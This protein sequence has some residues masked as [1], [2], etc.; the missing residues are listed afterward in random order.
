MILNRPAIAK[1]HLLRLSG[2]ALVLTL[3]LLLSPPAALAVGTGN[4]DSL[5]ANII[6]LGEDVRV[7]PTDSVENVVAFGGNI[8]VEGKVRSNVIAFGGDIEVRD[9]AVVGDGMTAEDF[10]VM[11]FG[12]TVSEAPGANVVGKTVDLGSLDWVEG[13]GE[14]LGAPFRG[15]S[16]TGWA[17]GLAFW[18]LVAFLAARLAPRQVEA[19]SKQLNRRPLPSLGWGALEALIIFP[20][21]TLLLVIT[22]VGIFAAVPLALFIMPILFLGG[23]LAAA[24]IA[25]KRLLRAAGSAEPGLIATTMVGVVVFEMLAL[26]PILGALLLGL[27]WLA[28]FGATVAALRDWRKNRSEGHMVSPAPTTTSGQG[29]VSVSS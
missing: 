6:R 24:S 22:V 19:V 21:I 25:G 4:P 5:D 10:A 17:I 13:A 28:G 14:A 15:G 20:L 9:G 3:L 26:V 27:V 11:S 23:Y 2:L 8:I 16:A 18:L 29:K 7:A 1:G 12:G